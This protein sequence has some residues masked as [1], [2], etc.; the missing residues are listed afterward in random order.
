VSLDVTSEEDL[1]PLQN[2]DIQIGVNDLTALSHLHEPAILH[3]LQ[4]RF[5]NNQVIQKPVAS[6]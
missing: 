6:L 4:H 5:K 1:P 3:N 2:P